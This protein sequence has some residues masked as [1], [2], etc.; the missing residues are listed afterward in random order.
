MLC[1]HG[2]A[3][4]LD[5][6]VRNITLASSVL[7]MSTASPLSQMASPDSSAFHLFSFL[8]AEL[9][10]KIWEYSLPESRIVP[11]RFDTPCQA[12]EYVNPRHRSSGCVSTAPIPTNLHVCHESRDEALKKYCLAFG[13]GDPGQI[14][15]NP[16]RDILYFGSREGKWA[17]EAQF[18]AFVSMSLPEDLALVRRLAINE[19]IF[20]SQAE[21]HSLVASRLTV[22]ILELVQ[23]RFPSLQELIFVPRDENPDYSGALVLQHTN[24]PDFRLLRQIHEGLQ[25]VVQENPQW[26]VPEWSIQ[27]LTVRPDAPMCE[28]IPAS[29]IS[30]YRPYGHVDTDAIQRVEMQST[31]SSL[32]Q[33]VLRCFSGLW[34]KRSCTDRMEHH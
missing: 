21:Y 32:D 23:S 1:H 20:W 22:E 4:C 25:V 31:L 26:L 14:F 2:R 28:L 11:V 16:A 8:P 13:M 17:T 9:R 19:C 30:Y 5:F 7:A 27:L 33:G 6:I 12:D 3:S 24:T 29:L 18:R 10:L 15:F 34:F